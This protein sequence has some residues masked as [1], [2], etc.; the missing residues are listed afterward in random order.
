MFFRT[1]DNLLVPLEIYKS[2]REWN[3]SI[4]HLVA[5]NKKLFSKSAFLKAFFT[6]AQAVKFRF[7]V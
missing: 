6:S 4:V 7:S 5:T 3:L 1:A 2:E